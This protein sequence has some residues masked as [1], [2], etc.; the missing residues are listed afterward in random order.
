MIPLSGD[1]LNDFIVELERRSLDASLIG[2][3]GSKSEVEIEQVLYWGKLREEESKAEEIGEALVAVL[4]SKTQEANSA[5]IDIDE[6]TRT[7]IE[8]ED[9]IEGFQ[10]LD[11][12][13][14][15]YHWYI[16]ESNAKQNVER[17]AYRNVY[18]R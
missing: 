5:P 17:A 9:L 18:S 3:I 15:E 4:A 7:F 1:T 8:K 2:A 13:E 12:R 11:L 16:R 10:V 14:G 6:L